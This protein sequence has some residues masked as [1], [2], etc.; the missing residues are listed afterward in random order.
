MTESRNTG[1]RSPLTR[2]LTLMGG[3]MLLG[4]AVLTVW[5][6]ITAPQARDYEPQQQARDGIN[7][8]VVDASAGDI[9]VTCGGSEDFV[10]TQEQVTEKWN[11]ERDGDTLKVSRTPQFRLFPGSIFK[12]GYA[13]EKVALSIPE[14]ACQQNMAADLS[15]SAGSL[16]VDARF[17]ALKVSVSAGSVEINGEAN[18]LKAKTSAG[19]IRLDLDGVEQADLEVSAGSIKGALRQVPENLNI[20]GSAGD[21]T[22]SLPAGNYNVN[23][24]VS[25]GSFNNNVNIDPQGMRSQIDVELSAGEVTLSTES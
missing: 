1:R 16:N 11:L 6:F 23:S 5:G 17:D 12:I 18:D 22:L 25:A 3:V 14:A 7:N 19:G 9:T 24:D 15:V 20:N 4:V 13:E 10:L 21:T 2:V 8:L